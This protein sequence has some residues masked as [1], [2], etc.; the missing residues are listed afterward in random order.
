MRTGWT[1]FAA[2]VSAAFVV[3]WARLDAEISERLNRERRKVACHFM[4]LEFLV[5]EEKSGREASV[6]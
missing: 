1:L 3:S 6:L 4:L 2:A 5:D